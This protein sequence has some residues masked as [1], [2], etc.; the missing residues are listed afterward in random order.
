M[1]I[2]PTVVLTSTIGA[3]TATLAVTGFSSLFLALV[4]AL[5]VVVGFLLVRISMQRRALR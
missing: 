5:L 3:G 1:Y 4:G 2:S